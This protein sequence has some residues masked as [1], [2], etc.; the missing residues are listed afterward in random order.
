MILG[1]QF[2]MEIAMKHLILLLTS[3]LFACSGT[4]FE[5]LDADPVSTTGGTGG[6]GSAG[7]SAQGGATVTPGGS[8]SDGGDTSSDGGAPTE[9]GADQGGAGGTVSCD[10]TQ[11]V[12]PTTWKFEDWSFS[13]DGGCANLV[14]GSTC[15]LEWNSVSWS[16]DNTMTAT[17][18]KID[19]GTVQLTAGGVCAEADQYQLSLESA[20][21]TTL[22]FTLAD[23]GAHGELISDILNTD[24]A[25]AQ[26][27]IAGAGGTIAFQAWVGTLVGDANRALRNSL[28]N[29]PLTCE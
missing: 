24:D 27:A 5:D 10:K 21:P 6:A 12:L 15:S 3:T 29:L 18:S 22:T 14:I 28:K 23:G 13:L 16:D 1:T 4:A 8:G 19:C 2:A 20:S 9:G 11:L 26:A 17:L 25:E 7:A